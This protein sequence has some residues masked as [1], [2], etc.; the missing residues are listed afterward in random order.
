MT[1]GYVVVKGRAVPV[2]SGDY[3]FVHNWIKHNALWAWTI[4]IGRVE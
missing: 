4:M 2:I 1:R 3:L